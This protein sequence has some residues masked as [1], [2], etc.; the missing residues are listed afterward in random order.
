MSKT[1]IANM[2]ILFYWN[3][4]VYHLDGI[5]FFFCKFYKFALILI[6]G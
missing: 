5:A 2:I 1:F 3:I 4:F 6:F